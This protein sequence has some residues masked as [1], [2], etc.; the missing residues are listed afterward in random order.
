MVSDVGN[1]SWLTLKLFKVTRLC[2]LKWPQ[3]TFSDYLSE[4][5]LK[6]RKQLIENEYLE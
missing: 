1:K 5:I 2:D 3:M 4:H 6:S